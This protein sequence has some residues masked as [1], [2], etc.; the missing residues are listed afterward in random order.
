MGDVFALVGKRVIESGERVA[1]EEWEGDDRSRAVGVGA[2]LGESWEEV[3]DREAGECGIDFRF[4]A[5]PGVD[6]EPMKHNGER[7]QNRA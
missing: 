4:E 6:G 3:F 2:E 1:G 5:G 7:I